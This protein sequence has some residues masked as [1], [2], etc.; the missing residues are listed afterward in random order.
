M[1]PALVILAAGLGRRFGSCKQREPVGPSGESLMEYAIYDALR[2]GFGAVVPIVSPDMEHIL[3][4][5]LRQR[6]GDRAV[7]TPVVQRKDELPAGYASMAKS[8]AKPWGTGQAVLAAR[9]VV[10]GPFAVINADDFYGREAIDAIAAHIARPRSSGIPTFAIAGYALRHTLSD[11]GA[12]S[13]A[14]CETDDAGILSSITEVLDIGPA[15]DDAICPDQTGGTRH[16]PGD[17]IVSMNLWGLTPAAF[18]ILEDGFRRFLDA[19]QA[20][21][22]AAPNEFYLPH[23]VQQAVDAKR[24]QVRILPAGDQWFGMTFA[25]DR[26]HVRARLA[27]LVQQGVYPRSLWA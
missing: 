16:L 23:A 12:V 5:D 15:G 14:V 18:G 22:C 11:S 13:R 25:S 17:T 3:G 7:V 10:S 20:P 1:K 9:N 26:E 6:V 21:D 19:Q 27:A 24:A 8:R 2:A 4:D